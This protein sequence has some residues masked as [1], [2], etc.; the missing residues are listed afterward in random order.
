MAAV[1]ANQ[2]LMK[3]T[4]TYWAPGT[5]DGY[6]ALTFA[7]G[8]SITCRWEDTAE[9]FTDGNG[10]Q[11][12]SSSV[13]YPDQVCE[14]DGWLYEGTSTEGDPRDQAGAQQI[15]SFRA[16]KSLRANFIEYKAVL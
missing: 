8:S 4:A 15:K 10:N 16:I 7:A 12:T 9:L 5:E 6:G 11:F 14:V 3:D 13:V 2:D 1:I